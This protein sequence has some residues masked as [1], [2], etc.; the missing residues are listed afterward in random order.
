M[1]RSL[2]VIVLAA[3][4]GK[5]NTV[6]PDAA[7][8]ASTPTKLTV[9]V[10]GNGHVTA[11]PGTMDCAGA[12]TET[13]VLG[14]TITLTAEGYSGG[15]FT[16]WGGACSGTDTCTFQLT[17]DTAVSAAF[18]CTGMVEFDYT[19]APQ[20]WSPPCATTLNVDVRGAGGGTAFWNGSS[21]P[22]GS[23]SLG[24]RV[25]GSI[26]VQQTDVLEIY[27]GGAGANAAMGVVGGGGYNGG[28]PG[29]AYLGTTSST[30]NQFGGGGG[31]ASDIRLN[32]A[33]LGDRVIVAGG[34]GGDSSCSGSPYQGGGGGGLIGGNGSACGGTAAGGGTQSAGGVG[35]TY[36][37]YCNAPAGTLGFGAP[38]CAAAPPLGTGGGGGGGGYYGGGGG[39]WDAGGGGS[40]YTATFVS[41]VIHTQG[42]QQGNGQVIISW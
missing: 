4:C 20:S 35:G 39:A 24:G 27:V 13:F 30:G 26:V 7:P 25:Q 8:D 22:I 36:S 14:A 11:T 1:S 21:T 33:A 31:G 3:A 41:G 40:S 9:M 12:C 19:G 23:P 15:S 18:G 37:G 38:A 32:S 17:G 29:A 5:V 42:F 6:K 16:G 34:A 10:T 28:A 2:L